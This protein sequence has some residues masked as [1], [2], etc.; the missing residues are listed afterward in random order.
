MKRKA[1]SRTVRRVPGVAADAPATLVESL[2]LEALDRIVA[3][4]TCNGVEQE[5]LEQAFRRARERHSRARRAVSVE[6]AARQY[7]AT[8]LL[9]AWH[10]D[11]DYLDPE[12][13]PLRLPLNG[14][15]PSLHGL[16]KRTGLTVP[17][18]DMVR[19]L[20]QIKAVRCVGQR[21]ATRRLAKPLLGTGSLANRERLRLVVRLLRSLEENRTERSAGNGDRTK[22]VTALESTEI[23]ERLLSVCRAQVT[24]DI[25]QF[26]R[27]LQSRM[28]RY[29][30]AR[31]RGE[32]QVHVGMGVFQ[33]EEVR[34]KGVRRASRRKKTNSERRISATSRSA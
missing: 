17:A 16:I 9:A 1:P 22:V 3:L 11:L 18:R 4:L 29:E 23:P 33:F 26:L 14:P 7:D 25:Q 34:P 6:S 20:E 19:Y 12:G 24:R 15:A 10:T 32:P 28:L 21:Y 30:R 31:V 5:A 8:L 13:R 2:T 27:E